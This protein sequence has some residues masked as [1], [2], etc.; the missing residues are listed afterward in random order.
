MRAV[1]TAG[2]LP[3]FNSQLPKFLPGGPGSWHLAVVLSAVLAVVAIPADA[4]EVTLDRR[5]IE[6]ALDIAHSSIES[7]HFR[8]HADY[9]FTVTTAPIDF[10]EIVSPF[11]RLVLE[12]ETSFLLGRRMF[13]QREALAAL[14][15]D[16]DRLEVY[17][18]LTFHPHNTLVNVPE[19]TVELV[20]VGVAGDPVLP[21][22]IDRLPRFGPR[23]NDSRYPFPYPYP[24]APRVPAGTEPLLGGTLIARM[25]GRSID[26][27]GVYEVVVKDGDKELGRTWRVHLGRLR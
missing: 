17:V 5:A 12:A 6:E 15:P 2:K 26:P 14:Q 22:T 21:G 13:G 11:R 4:I 18:E 7:T 24:V 8:F 25:P 1:E 20:P 19:Y 9:R 23:V 10:V 3:T 16:P 27:K